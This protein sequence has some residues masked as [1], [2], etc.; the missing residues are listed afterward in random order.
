MAGKGT[1]VQ[2]LVSVDDEHMSQLDK[3]AQ[4]CREAGLE[5]DQALGA[6]G[7][8]TGSIPQSKMSSLSAV[9]GVASVERGQDYQIAP[10]DSEIQ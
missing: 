1:K 10:P 9:K 3:V 8:I 2:V 7:I 4:R 6:V 5:V